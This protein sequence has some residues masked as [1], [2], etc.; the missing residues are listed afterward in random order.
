M[1]Y[2]YNPFTGDFDRVDDTTSSSQLTLTGNSGG[3]VES[4]TN[5]NIYLLGSTPMVVT[6]DPGTH[7]LTI[8]TDGTLATIFKADTGT[9][10]PAADNLNILG[11]TA[12]AGTSPVETSGSGSTVTLEVQVSQA[13]AA[14][15]A[16]KIG[17]CNFESTDF[18]VDTDGF[19]TLTAGGHKFVEII[20]DSGISPV[21]AD[22]NGKTKLFGSGSITSVGGLNLLTTELT[23]LTQY[24][25]LVGAGSPTITKVAPGATGIPLV[26]KGA[27]SDPA[28]ST[29]A[30]AG[31][32]TGVTSL[33]D[34]GVLLGSGAGPVTATPQ[35]TN[36]LVL[37]GSTGTDPAFAPI[38][39]ADGS[40][41]F[42]TGSNSLDLA[43]DGG[44]TT[45]KTL[46]GDSGGALPPTSGNWNILGSTASA[47]TSPVETSGSGSTV[48]LEVQV[49]QA[50]AAADA[51]KIGL[52]NF[53]SNHFSVDGAGFVDINS[54]GL[55]DLK[56]L[57]L[58]VPLSVPSG[59]TG[60]ATITD[61]GI[62]LGS[63]TGAVT[64]LGQAT[65]GQL[66]IG[67]TGA[68]PV[69]NTLASADSSV[70]ITNGSGTID[71]AVAVVSGFDWNVITANQTAVVNNG[72][73]CNKS[74]PL[75]LLLPATATAGDIIRVTGLNTV[76]GMKI[77]QNASQQIHMG[78]VSTTIGITGYIQSS[79]IRDALE[80][81]AVV[82]GSS[83]VWNV[84][85]S[86]G[87]WT[88][89]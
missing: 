58:Q 6:G 74:S 73:I 50:L 42:V 54:A 28:F 71:L 78:N 66:P 20:P 10:T 63:G 14:A 87:I 5:E 56:S 52:C 19:V 2:K 60:L 37:L 24:N 7:T 89:S 36:G 75:Q 33:T 12:S 76:L 21:V 47:G 82:S 25:V 8:D 81:V 17:L 9:A 62:M 51:T 11:S 55:F 18:A 32:G 1:G 64:P 49:S 70:T 88:L 83:T 41:S 38:T 69:L 27:T 61:G 67:N 53:E 46:T 13:L 43:V 30:V 72:Y 23:G 44:T 57:N 31:G 48:T 34:G 77:T 15:D 79:A 26:S 22:G 29:A 35:P 3:V 59:G 39:S 84:L 16:T 80:L 40:I 65:N 45:G 68:D 4:D 85:S 86:F